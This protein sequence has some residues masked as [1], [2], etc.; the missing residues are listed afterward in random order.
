ML[1]AA[2]VLLAF[3]FGL[4]TYQPKPVR[5]ALV[6]AADSVYQPRGGDVAITLATE[7]HP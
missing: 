1:S 3:G 7:V 4:G 5:D 2:T 6:R